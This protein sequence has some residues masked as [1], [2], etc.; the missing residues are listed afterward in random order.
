VVPNGDDTMPMPFMPPQVSG[1]QID[2]QCIL[3]VMD[4]LHS[5]LELRN[6]LHWAEEEGKVPMFVRTVATAARMA[7][8]PDYELLRPVVVELKRRYPEDL[9][10]R[11]QQLR[12]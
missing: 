9:R 4:S 3:S 1:G 11:P 2:W 8:M 5:D 12:T 7:C 6:W 10:V